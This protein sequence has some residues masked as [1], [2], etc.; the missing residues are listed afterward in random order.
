MRFLYLI[1]GLIVLLS[2]TL[3]NLG[4]TGGG[5]SGW[6]SGANSRGAWSSS[7]GHK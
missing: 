5:N 3:H 4:A 1:Y 2:T 7:G 6:S